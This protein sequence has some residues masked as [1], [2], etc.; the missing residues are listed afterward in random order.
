MNWDVLDNA[1]R[2]LQRPPGRAFTV[3]QLCERYGISRWAARKRVEQMIEAGEIEAWNEPQSGRVTY[4]VFVN[5]NE[6]SR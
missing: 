3:P 4:Y 5:G 1:F 6:R 2:D